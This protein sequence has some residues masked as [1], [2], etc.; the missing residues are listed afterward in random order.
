MNK[1]M[2]SFV[3]ALL[4][5][6]LLPSFGQTAAEKD[7]AYL[8]IDKALDLKTIRPEVNINLPRFLL[9]DAAS[10]LTGTNGSSSSVQ[11][12]DIA[13]LIKDV[14]LIRSWSRPTR[15]IAR[16]WTKP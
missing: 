15:P 10:E 7:P 4:A 2:S 3:F 8:P 9:K 6:S 13:D 11:G 14:K 16:L 1:I 5:M 12:I